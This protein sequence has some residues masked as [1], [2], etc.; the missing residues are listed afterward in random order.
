MINIKNTKLK[1]NVTIIN[2]SKII[3]M[4]IEKYSNFN[5]KI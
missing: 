1:K 2:I 4:L 3:K 5:T